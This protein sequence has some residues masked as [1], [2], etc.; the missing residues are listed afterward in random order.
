MF[1]RD[2]EGDRVS[3]PRISLTKK[4]KKERKTD[5]IVH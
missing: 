3:E 2:A 4:K 1:Q 5:T